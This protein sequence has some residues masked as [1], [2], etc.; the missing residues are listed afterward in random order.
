MLSAAK[1][2]FCR[3]NFNVDGILHTY[4]LIKYISNYRVLDTDDEDSASDDMTSMQASEL[5]SDV[6]KGYDASGYSEIALSSNQINDAS[7]FI[8]SNPM[9]VRERG[10]SLSVE[11]TPE[12]L[13]VFPEPRSKSLRLKKTY[14]DS[15][16]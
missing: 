3:Y 14:K 4:F 1:R 13:H 8:L 2:I 11:R 9:P 6:V 7:L 16:K 10:H 5:R 15:S 12:L